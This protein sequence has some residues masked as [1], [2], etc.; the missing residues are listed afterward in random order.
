MTLIEG[1]DQVILESYARQVNLMSYRQ[2]IH[3]MFRLSSYSPHSHGTSG[4][5]DFEDVESVAEEVSYKDWFTGNPDSKVTSS[6]RNVFL[7]ARVRERYWRAQVITYRPFVSMILEFNYLKKH[8]GRATIPTQSP[9]RDGIAHPTITPSTQTFM[10]LDPR[11]VDMARKG[12][13]ALIES[14]RVFH[15]LNER[16]PILTSVFCTA[17]TYVH[18]IK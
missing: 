16:R 14:T 15:H 18:V 4:Q 1:V 13:T 6:L 7:T 3:R 8:S 17:H 12:L 2:K 5:A 11:L 9:F 10:D